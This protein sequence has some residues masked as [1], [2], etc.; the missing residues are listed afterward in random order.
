MHWRGRD[1]VEYAHRILFGGA[2]RGV[3]ETLEEIES[4]VAVPGGA[5]IVVI[6][7]A[8]GTYMTPSGQLNPPGR[9]RMTLALVPRGNRLVIAH[10]ANIAIVEAAQRSDSVR[11]RRE[12]PSH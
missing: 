2:L 7:W 12:R 11:Q 1:E 10:G 8:I 9:T 5:M 6:R 4:V 3:T